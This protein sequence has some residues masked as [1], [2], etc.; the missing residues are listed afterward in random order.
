MGFT[1]CQHQW[2]L[3]SFPLLCIHVLSEVC[4]HIMLPKVFTHL[5]WMLW[6]TSTAEV[7]TSIHPRDFLLVGHCVTALPLFSDMMRRSQFQC[8]TCD[9]LCWLVTSYEGMSVI[10]WCT[11][12]QVSFSHLSL[13]FL[14][15]LKASAFTS[16]RSPGFKFTA[17]IFL[18]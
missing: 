5:L 2:A 3:T 6:W 15:P 8:R 16:T 14:F 18:L 9:F 11:T 12:S 17:P 1:I 13:I 10:I 4:S 7:I